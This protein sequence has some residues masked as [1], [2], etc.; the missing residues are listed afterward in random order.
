MQGVDFLSPSV[1]NSFLMKSDLITRAPR[2]ERQQTGWQRRGFQTGIKH[3]W[4]Q[5]TKLILAKKN[6]FHF[7]KQ[8]SVCV[9]ACTTRV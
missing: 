4:K 6:I 9:N 3:F 5:L 2:S 1:F 8:K 7:E